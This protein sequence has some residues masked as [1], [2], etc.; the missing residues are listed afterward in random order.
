MIVADYMT[1]TAITIGSD[2]AIMD[3]ARLMLD[4]NISGLP[5]LDAA[6][7]LVGIISESDLL[8]ERDDRDEAQRPRWLEYMIERAEKTDEA[9]RFQDRKVS[10][11]MTKDPVVVGPQTSLREACRLLERRRI[12]RLPVVQ[13]G[14]LVGILARADL[15]RAF[16]RAT[17][18]DAIAAKPD[19][20][21]EEQMRALERQNWR[22]RARDF[23]PI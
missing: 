13:N 17:N 10:D 6:G 8:R 20:S 1:R 15:V 12:K 9:A 2:A 5:V 21:V 16:A 22:T 4:H 19:V 23:K 18:A 3:A 7:Q 14:K 11:A